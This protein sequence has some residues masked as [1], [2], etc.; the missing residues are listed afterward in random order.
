[1]RR[2]LHSGGGHPERKPCSGP[3]WHGL[4]AAYLPPVSR[5]AIVSLVIASPFVVLQTLRHDRLLKLGA[6]AAGHAFE[7]NRLAAKGRPT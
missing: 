3:T 5:S 6:H 7:H 2:V 4:P 1:M